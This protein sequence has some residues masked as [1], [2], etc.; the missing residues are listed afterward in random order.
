LPKGTPIV[1]TRLRGAQS[2]ICVLTD[3]EALV[4]GDRFRTLTGVVMAIPN[5]DVLSVTRWPPAG[6]SQIQVQVF[7]FGVNRGL[8]GS[9]KSG[10][11][12]CSLQRTRTMVNSWLQAVLPCSSDCL[13]I[14]RQLFKRAQ[15]KATV[16]IVTVDTPNLVLTPSLKCFCLNGCTS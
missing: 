2:N 16:Q 14:H 7:L 3:S 8:C 15:G 5:S 12:L 10:P 1:G 13:L 6:L 11:P 4:Q 9:A